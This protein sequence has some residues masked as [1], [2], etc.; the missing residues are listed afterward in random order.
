[1]NLVTFKDDENRDGEDEY[2]D[3]N[4][5]YLDRNDDYLDGNGKYH[6]DDDDDERDPLH[7]VCMLS[8][9]QTIANEIVFVSLLNIS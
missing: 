5:E 8:C 1:M 9:Q 4:D 3:G 2:L 6:D 7:C